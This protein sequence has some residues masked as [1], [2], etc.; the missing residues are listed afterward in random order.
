MKEVQRL[1]A[2]MAR[3]AHE[4]PNQWKVA[5]CPAGCGENYAVPHALSARGGAVVCHGCTHR[6]CPRCDVRWADRLLPGRE[7]THEGRSCADVA[8]LRASLVVLTPHD[9]QAQGIKPCPRC[10]QGIAKD[11]G[12]AV[13]TCGQHTHAAGGLH[14]GCG[15][16]F[17]WECGEDNGPA[18]NIV[19]QGHQFHLAT[20]PYFRAVGW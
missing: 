11:G 5:P 4:Q 16:V 8:R 19:R 17:C 18:S 15:F 14:G 13:M 7:E 9:M 6:V 3:D 20:C 1:R 10:G 12:C 2:A